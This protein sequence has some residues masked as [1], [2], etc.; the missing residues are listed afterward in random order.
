MDAFD[1]ALAITKANGSYSE[2]F[3]PELSSG[4]LFIPLDCA[5]D[6]SLF[7]FPARTPGTLLDTVL[8]RGDIRSF[9]VDDPGLNTLMDL[10]VS[11]ISNHYGVPLT[12]VVLSFPDNSTIAIEMLIAGIVDLAGPDF[13]LGGEFMGIAR[14]RVTQQSCATT[15][16]LGVFTVLDN[17]PFTSFADL[18]SAATLT[19][20][21]NAEGSATIY[22]SVLPN[23]DVTVNAAIPDADIVAA[24]R[25]GTINVVID[26]DVAFL[27]TEGIDVTGLRSFFGGFDNPNG[28]LFAI[29]CL[30]RH[31]CGKK[32]Q[33]W[34]KSSM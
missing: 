9:Q 25:T 32:N 18:Q 29:R 23:L 3:A 6:P 1:S 4:A 31:R 8:S 24:L 34:K 26:L 13:S 20:L 17:S 10:M 27:A 19:T 15:D 30:P 21:T 2:I 5:A 22:S 28:S 14:K 12:R 11:I 7:P 16:G 33:K